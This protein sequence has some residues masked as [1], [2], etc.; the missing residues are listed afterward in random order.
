VSIA[1]SNAAPIERVTIPLRPRTPAGCCDLAVMYYGRHLLPALRLLL[2]IAG[3]AVALIYGLSRFVGTDFTVTVIALVLISKALGVLTVAAV[4]RTTFGEPFENPI[5]P[6]WVRRSRL[7]RLREFTRNLVTAVTWLAAGSMVIAALDDAYGTG[8]LSAMEPWQSAAVVIGLSAV[9]LVRSLMFISDRHSPGRHVMRAMF[10]G[11]LLRALATVPLVLLLFDET[12]IVGIVLAIFWL[13]A[14]AAAA[15]W[16]SFG[17]ER[18]ALA[19]I[20]RS[21]DMTKHRRTQSWNDMFGSAMLVAVS[22]IMLLAMCMA[23][24]EYGLY[25]VGMEG[26]VLGPVSDY[27]N[28]EFF[29][30]TLA[31]TLIGRNPLFAATFVVAALFAYQLARVAWFFTFIDA[32]VRSDC[33]DLELVLAREAKRLEGE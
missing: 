31:I 26:P 5:P 3:P 30:P 16:F 17:A 15:L 21:L 24:I 1:T 4:A 12:W 25:A 14:Y 10:Q 8:R 13:P 22:A 20:D 23:A 18:R 6:R 7:D 28:P 29:D 33:W 9:L 11:L 27:L 32:R 19:E 2:S